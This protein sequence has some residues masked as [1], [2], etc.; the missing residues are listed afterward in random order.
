MAGP[1][2]KELGVRSPLKLRAGIDFPTWEGVNRQNDPGAIRDTQFQTAVNVRINGNEVIS[3]GGQT[4]AYNSGVTGCIYG[5]IDVGEG[6][7]GIFVWDQHGNSLSP[8]KGLFLF[9]PTA[10]TYTN[11]IVSPTALDMSANPIRNV[12]PF[13]G[14]LFIFG[15]DPV[16]LVTGLW[17]VALDS[18]SK[19]TIAVEIPEFNSFAVRDESTPGG[20]NQA[21]YIGTETTNTVYRWDGVTLTTEATGVGS[22]ALI[23]FTYAGEVY[24]ASVNSLKARGAT[25]SWSTSYAMPGGIT[26]FTPKR[27]V[28]YVSQALICGS[29]TTVGSEARVLSFN[30]SALSVS[31]TD[32][33]TGGVGDELFSDLAVGG[34]L[35]WL[36]YKSDTGATALCHLASYNG[37]SWTLEF[38][39]SE[40]TNYAGALLALEND[41][42]WWTSNDC[43]DTPIGGVTTATSMVFVRVNGYDP[44]NM[45][46]VHSTTGPASG[47][48]CPTDMN[49]LN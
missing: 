23:M 42:Y 34:G 17:E 32:S 18:T 24:A 2:D 22:G 26:S 12:V 31:Y 21:M 5:M 37:S 19:W 40:P 49:V 13:Q 41:L 43:S 16:S 8:D 39:C 30:G 4:R 7:E 38:D 3:R 11:L 20:A 29:D 48:A 15:Q 10:N 25:A 45:S 46:V 6:E 36:S 27:G 9:K 35:A 44:A 28:E 47:E 33:N 14:K 1:K